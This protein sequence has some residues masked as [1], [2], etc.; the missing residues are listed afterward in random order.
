MKALDCFSF[1]KFEADFGAST[2][3][4]SCKTGFE[5]TWQNLKKNE[6]QAVISE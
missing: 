4:L 5:T 6:E 3:I 2:E 1:V